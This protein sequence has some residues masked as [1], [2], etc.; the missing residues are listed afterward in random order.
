MFLKLNQFFIL[1]RLIYMSTLNNSGLVNTNTNN[2]VIDINKSYF[3]D[4]SYSFYIYTVNS[5]AS[6]SSG[7]NFL[8]TTRYIPGLWFAHLS[9][10]F[11]NSPICSIGI[12]TNASDSSTYGTNGTLYD[13]GQGRIQ[14]PSGF[15][16]VSWNAVSG[17]D[18]GSTNA[19]S[20]SCMISIPN[21]Q[22]DCQIGVAVFSQ[23]SNPYTCILT[24]VNIG[25]PTS[26][27]QLTS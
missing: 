15:Y 5:S 18:A 27:Q 3:S 22:N 20:T 13:S 26:V 11:S 25:P 9:A 19:C 14:A 24:L 6:S 12:F 1:F 2:L 17:F 23:S 7:E 10:S 16:M 4:S 8:P 21:S